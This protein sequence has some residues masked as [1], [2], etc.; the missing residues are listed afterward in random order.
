MTNKPRRYLAIL[1]F[2]MF[3]LAEADTVIVHPDVNVTRLSSQSLRSIFTMRSTRWPDQKVIHVF[4]LPDSHLLHR[5]FVKTKLDMFPY[6]LRMIWDRSVYS[7]AGF[8]PTLVMS[9]KEVLSRV[10]ATKG[11]IGYVN[12]SDVLLMDGVKTIEIE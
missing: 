1:L 6:Q 11:S 2:L 4:V 7:G 9:E 8:A 10:K 5:S 3:Q 12:T